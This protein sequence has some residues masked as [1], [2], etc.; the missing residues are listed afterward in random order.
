MEG[1]GATDIRREWK[2]L[3]WGGEPGTGRNEI[4]VLKPN[5]YIVASLFYFT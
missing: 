3:T 5:C 2:R 4:E 1:W